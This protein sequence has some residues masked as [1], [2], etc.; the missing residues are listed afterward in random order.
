[1]AANI[2]ALC[3]K[4]RIT[5]FIELWSCVDLTFFAAATLSFTLAVALFLRIDAI[6]S[7]L[8]ISFVTSVLL[9]HAVGECVSPRPEAEGRTCVL[10]D[11]VCCDA[12]DDY[13]RYESE[14]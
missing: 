2:V 12:A 6:L 10:V 7:A 4:I 5:I 14:Q 8:F 1:M 3:V 9:H 13:Q 11:F